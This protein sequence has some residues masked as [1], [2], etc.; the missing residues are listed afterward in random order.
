MANSYPFATLI[1]TY[2]RLGIPYVSLIQRDLV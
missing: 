2:V 1:Q